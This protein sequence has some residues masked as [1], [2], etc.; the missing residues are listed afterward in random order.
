MV[1]KKHRLTKADDTN[2]LQIRYIVTG[3][4]IFGEKYTSIILFAC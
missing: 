4:E 2:L 3:H 1:Q